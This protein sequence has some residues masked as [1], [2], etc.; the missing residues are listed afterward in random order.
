LRA[1]VVEG[2]A[3]VPLSLDAGSPPKKETQDDMVTM[4]QA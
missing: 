4:M 2:L 1:A 3:V